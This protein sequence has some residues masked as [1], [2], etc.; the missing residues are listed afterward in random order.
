MNQVFTFMFIAELGLKL[1]ALG[2]IS[3]IQ[4]KMNYLDGGVVILSIVE[5]T[6]ISGGRKNTLSAFRT[7]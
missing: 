3:Y 1:I 2:P 4:D 6:V 5:L 7:I